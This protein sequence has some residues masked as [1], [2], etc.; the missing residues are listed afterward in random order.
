MSNNKQQSKRDRKGASSSPKEN[1]TF[2]D[3]TNKSTSYKEENSTTVQNTE[4]KEY[5]SN[6][7]PINSPH[8]KNNSDIHKKER[9]PPF[10]LEED[11][12]LMQ[13][14]RD[15]LDVASN[16]LK[17]AKNQLIDRDLKRKELQNNQREAKG[18][19]KSNIKTLSDLEEKKK[20]LQDKIIDEERQKK[21]KKDKIREVRV[22]MES[23]WPFN[24]ALDPDNKSNLGKIDGRIK[25]LEEKLM[26]TVSIM[27]EKKMVGE[28]GNLNQLK[29]LLKDYFKLAQNYSETRSKTLLEELKNLDQKITKKKELGESQKKTVDNIKTEMKDLNKDTSAYNYY[30]EIQDD[31]SSQYDK[32]G[33][34]KEKIDEQKKKWL[35]ERALERKTQKEIKKKKEKE[36]EEARLKRIQ[37][38]F[39][40][41]SKELPFSE[42]INLCDKL[43]EELDKIKSQKKIKDDQPSEFGVIR[44]L[45]T[46]LLFEE[47]SVDPPF[48]MD[49]IPRSKQDLQQRKEWL[50]KQQELIL[51][52]D[53]Q[54]L[55]VIKME[56]KEEDEDSLKQNEYQP[57]VKTEMNFIIYY[58]ALKQL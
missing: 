14:I 4:K 20:Q 10:I 32:R 44:T 56:S 3:K 29:S 31:I 35:E 46:L 7:P 2:Q 52:E 11:R 50:L 41:E 38:R 28:I 17:E 47:L 18:I 48:I 24:V 8:T 22:S 16:K 6:R 39:M 53:P 26:S 34:L 54:I 33:Q 27:D 23:K 55:E 36:K 58:A 19:L 15:N 25:I 51:K 37:S 42:D 49:Q 40:K 9:D 1:D 12:K 45:N 43:L 13:E 30:T 21:M 5:P 57:K